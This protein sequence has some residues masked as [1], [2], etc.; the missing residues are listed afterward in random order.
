MSVSS[1]EI[2]SDHSS[3]QTSKQSNNILSIPNLYINNI[4]VSKETKTK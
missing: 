2:I 3:K 1:I 4:T